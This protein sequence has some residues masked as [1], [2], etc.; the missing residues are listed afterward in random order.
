MLN[1]RHHHYSHSHHRSQAL[2]VDAA[3]AAG[4][5]TG[6]RWSIPTRLDPGAL[7]RG[8]SS[9]AIAAFALGP[10]PHDAEATCP[11]TLSP[12]DADLAAT[13]N[14]WTMALPG[15]AGAFDTVASFGGVGLTWRMG[16]FD[17]NKAG[18]GDEVVEAL[19][20][21]TSERTDSVT[22]IFERPIKA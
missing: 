2:D 12:S 6:Y 10:C 3:D 4:G 20:S 9:P 1:L 22:L 15:G 19:V 16:M 8:L 7:S 21:N 14:A 5:L 11:L 17:V 18:S 13:A